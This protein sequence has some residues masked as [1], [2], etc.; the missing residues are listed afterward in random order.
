MTPSTAGQHLRQTL[1]QALA[2]ASQDIGQPLEWAEDEVVAI[3]AAVQAADRA[4]D[5]RRIYDAE[6]TGEARPTVLVKLSAELRQLDRQV[7]E[8]AAR[9]NPG[10][11]PAKSARH[12]RAANARWRRNKE[13]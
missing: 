10:V 8:L 13:A 5:L 12:V 4:A 6:R 9:V 7:V 3:E 11:G 2:R 1:D